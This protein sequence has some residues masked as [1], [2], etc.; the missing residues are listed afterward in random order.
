MKENMPKIKI[1]IISGGW[2]KEKDISIKSGKAVYGALN[3]EKFEVSVYD[4]SLGLDLLLREKHS[5]D[6]AFI[7]LH[8]R[9]GED[10]CIQGLLS[11][12]GIPFVGSGVAASAMASNKKIAKDIYRTSGLS[13]IDDVVLEKGRAFLL[14][15]IIGILGQKTIVKP[16]SEGSSFGISV[17]NNKDELQQGIETAFLYDREIIIEKF[18]KGREV[19]CCVLGNDSLETL[20]IVE[21]IPNND[22]QFFN[23]EAKYKT[24]GAKEIC[25]AELPAS[26]LENIMQNAKAAHHALRCSVWSRTD[27]IIYD[28]EVFILETNTVPGMTENSLFPLAARVAGLSL[29]QLLDKL[30][31]L[32]LEG[33]AS[34]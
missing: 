18:L 4:P 30:I 20:P 5:I 9:F 10:G 21:V 25:P 17:C 19:T 16:V 12:L 34:R 26:I 23:Y 6:L 24:G 29:S 27:M 2:S 11:I 28:N 8:G 31:T 15:D 14:D 3:K 32:S 7:L 22:H 13:V 1:A 33:S